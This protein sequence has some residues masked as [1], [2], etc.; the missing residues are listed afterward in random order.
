L[1]HLVSK[2]NTTSRIQ[3]TDKTTTYEIEWATIMSFILLY[4]VLKK[5]L[6]RKGKF[7][8]RL[9]VSLIHR[10][11]TFFLWE[12]MVGNYYWPELYT[13]RVLFNAPCVF[14]LFLFLFSSLLLAAVQQINPTLENNV[15]LKPVRPTFKLSLNPCR[16]PSFRFVLKLSSLVRF[17]VWWA[18][19]MV[20]SIDQIH[21][22]RSFQF[23]L[24]ES[25]YVSAYFAY[26]TWMKEY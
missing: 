1:Y 6:F 9:L 21:F 10:P 12:M 11:K 20:R 18:A 4:K 22:S 25:F 3:F 19:M 26:F 8:L 2:P 7:Y 16:S 5:R 23:F 14:Y 17:N 24:G 13:S 15:H